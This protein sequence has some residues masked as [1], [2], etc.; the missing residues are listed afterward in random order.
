M[1]PTNGVV[2]GS[3]VSPTNIALVQ[4]KEVMD[5]LHLIQAGQKDFESRLA[6]VEYVLI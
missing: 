5:A 4:H 6:R 3:L 1:P 2:D